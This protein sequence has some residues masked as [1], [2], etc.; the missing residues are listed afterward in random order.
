MLDENVSPI[1]C[2]KSLSSRSASAIMIE[3]RDMLRERGRKKMKARK[4][5]I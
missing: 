2:S 1:K 4:E 5:K 3:G